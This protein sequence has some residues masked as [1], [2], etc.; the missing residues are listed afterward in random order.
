MSAHPLDLA[1]FG[2]RL[3]CGLFAGVITWLVAA[4]Y[5][6]ALVSRWV[7][8]DNAAAR[9]GVGAAFGYALL[10][11]SV[12][13]LGLFHLIHPWFLY[14][15][16]AVAVALRLPHWVRKF[17]ANKLAHSCSSAS[18]RAS[19]GD[20]AASLVIA[21]AV[22]TGIIAAALPA[23]WWDP[24]AYH[25]PL[26]SM[27]LA[28]GT[29]VFSPHM[30]QTGF[31]QLGE[32]AALPAYAIAGSAGA[33]M[34]TLGAGLCLAFLAGVLANRVALGSGIA[35]A[36]LVCSCPLWLWLAP[37]FYVDIPFAMFVV[38]AIAVILERK[39]DEAD[40]KVGC[41]TGRVGWSSGGVGC[42]MI[43]GSLGGAGAAVK[44][45]GLV[46]CAIVL[47]FAIVRGRPQWWKTSAAYAA[48]AVVI[49]AGW[50]L[51]TFAATGDPL[52]PFLSL[53]FAH[54]SS[55][56]SFAARYI[57]MTRHWCGGGSSPSD[58]LA[59][60]YRLLVTPRSFCGD[61]GLGLRT[62]IMFALAAIVTIRVAFPIALLTVA[63]TVAWFYTSQQWR[64]AIAPVATYAALVAAGTTA[65]GARLRPVFVLA[66]SVLGAY[67]IAVNWLPFELPQATQSLVPGVAYV[68]GR[69]TASQYVDERLETYAAA[70]WL[71]ERNVPGN[72]I[73]ALDDV[74]DYYFP[75]GTVWANP[76]YQ[77][78]L[79]VD[80]QT[81]AQDRYAR[82][83]A[84]GFRYL[85]VNANEAY[86]GRT[87]TGIAW[88]VFAQDAH[89]V[90]HEEF[91]RNGVA[92]YS[93]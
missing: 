37:T 93:L 21:F 27:A 47:V 73:L 91:Q 15:L 48:G 45:S 3:F 10:G 81:G 32:A 59:L 75:A 44:Y 20:W 76:Y 43:A 25:L 62:G 92:I 54:A 61:P 8:F 16:L 87:P 71:W 31:P 66:L 28:R 35:A 42:Y 18:L 85:V 5:G 2:P 79:T 26:V 9:I 67:S 38:A 51:R 22:L 78:A 57:D 6:S 84:L 11:S 68:L 29:I 24:I 90:L 30:V 74:R 46:A 60:P 65:L 40:L 89:T 58:L 83:R 50:Y 64:F 41:Y 49:S 17:G 53:Q 80:W 12:A 56:A 55:I 72:E 13:V 70:R 4:D 7:K 14:I 63:L 1:G 36:M 19:T 86:I 33:A 39:E 82:L 77:Q 88:M 23:V 69:Q 34:A 52:Y